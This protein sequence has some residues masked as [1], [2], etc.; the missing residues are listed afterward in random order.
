VEYKRKII[1]KQKTFVY[2]CKTNY[3][4]VNTKKPIRVEKINIDYYTGD[5]SPRRACYFYK[6]CCKKKNMNR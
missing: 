5:A 4:I 1:V 6:L 2:T 3:I